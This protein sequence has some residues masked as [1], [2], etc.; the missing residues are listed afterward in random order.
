MT[1]A[2]ILDHFFP[3]ILQRYVLSRFLSVLATCLLA[4]VSIFVVFDIF[5]KIGVFLKEGAPLSLLLAYTGY[6]IPLIVQLMMPIAVLV[7]SILSV[8]RLSQLS[9]ITAMRA[10]GLSI[11]TLVL[12]ILAVGFSLS[13]LSF[14]LGET[15]IPY[16][17]QRSEEIYNLDVRRKAEKGTASR[18]NFW[19]RSKRRLFNV[20][21]YD[22]RSSTLHE[23]SIFEV[24]DNFSPARRIDAKTA[25]WGGSSGI[26]WTMKDVVEITVNEE[27][28]AATSNFRQMPLIIE[29][30]PADF[31]NLERRAETMSYRQLKRYVKKL[32][33]EGVSVTG[34]LVDLA[35]KVSFPFVNLV[36]VLVGFP[37][38]LISARMGNLTLS[39]I[40]GV[41]IGFGYYVIHALSVSL[42]SGELIP[43]QLAAWSANIIVSSIGLYFMAG[44][45]WK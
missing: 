25:H 15:V 12:P 19:Y 27:G 40:Y 29:E 34:Y 7:A 4:S 18:N 32:S 37:F 16:A 28:L 3:G 38:A 26:G 5:E 17:T 45:D 41:S 24:G 2:K 35:A 39:F 30:V 21:Y 11:W 13:L 8:G 9:E 43:I 33:T 36:V 14:V 31:Y 44:A 1:P 20:G 22:S 23:V 42:G 6:K 10:A